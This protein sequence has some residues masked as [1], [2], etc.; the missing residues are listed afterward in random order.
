MVD[1]TIDKLSLLNL[2]RRHN[3]NSKIGIESDLAEGG[4]NLGLCL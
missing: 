1:D 2:M 3:K 4:P